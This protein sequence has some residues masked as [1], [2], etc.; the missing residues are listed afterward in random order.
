[1]NDAP[2]LDEVSRLRNLCAAVYQV[3]GA[4]N[5]SAT[6]LDALSAAASGTYDGNPDDLLPY[7]AHDRSDP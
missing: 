4:L 2:A 7:T 3:C 5:A 6:V 1:M